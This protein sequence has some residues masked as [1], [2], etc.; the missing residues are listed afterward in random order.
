MDVI[1]DLHTLDWS[2]TALAFRGFGVTNL[3]RTTDLWQ[4]DEYRVLLEDAL[5]A[6]SNVCSEVTGRDID[7]IEFVREGRDPDVESYPQAL[8]LIVA[9]EVGQLN[10]LKQLFGADWMKSQVSFGYSLGEIAALVA[11]GVFELKEALRIPLLLADDCV[12]LSGEVT[13]AV[14]FS[15]QHVIPFGDVQRLCYQINAEGR[16]VIGISAQLTPNSF[17][18]IGQHDTVDRFAQ[19][20][21][22]ALPKSTRIH[23]DSRHWP[24]IH[25][26]ILWERNVADRACRLMHTVDGGF[27]E[28]VPPVLSLV[29]GELSYND[30]NARD[31][32]CRWT[33]HPILLWKAVEYVLAENI[34]TVIHIGPSPKIIPATF[35]RMSEYVMTQMQSWPLR[36]VGR[37]ARNRWMAT[38]LPKRATLLRAPLIQHV[39]LE[40]W[41]LEQPAPPLSDTES[42]PESPVEGTAP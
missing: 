11:G 40:D 17:I 39:N 34:D 21:H 31:L 27:R 18:I 3:G 35:R 37:I 16:G 5:R 23:R 2:R 32:L 4:R 14:L 10:I 42:V 24:P 36:T 13:L 22:E 12:A 8:S 9:V 41:L 6:A 19:R 33:D 38:L 1:S 28:P 29:T 26:P 20:M 25:T 30:Y 15:R 7:L